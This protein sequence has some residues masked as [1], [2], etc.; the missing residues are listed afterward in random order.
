MLIEET[1]PALW[2]E[3][4]HAGVEWSGNLLHK[5]PT[6][7][8]ESMNIDAAQGS[9]FCKDKLGLDNQLLL[10]SSKLQTFSANS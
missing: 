10:N 2:L 4:V 8:K 7:L 5:C 6:A 9:D 3:S 1:K